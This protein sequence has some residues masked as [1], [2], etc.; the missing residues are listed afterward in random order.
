MP[1]LGFAEFEPGIDPREVVETGSRAKGLSNPTTLLEQLFFTTVRIETTLPDKSKSTGTGFIFNYHTKD[2]DF[3]YIVTN[4]H[5]VKNS[6]EGTLVFNRMQF[7]LPKLGDHFPLEYDNFEKHWTFHD[8]D[9]VDLA[10]LPFSPVLHQLKDLKENIYYKWLDQSF[11]PND[12]KI[13]EEFDAVEDLLFLGY[14]NNIY[15]KKNLTPVVRKGITATP[16][17]ENYENN[18]KFLVDASIFPGSSG[19]PIFIIK[20]SKSTVL[21]KKQNKKQLFLLGVIASVFIK[22]DINKVE[23]IEI[24]RRHEQFVKSAQMIDLG[25][26]FK[27]HLF[28]EM[29]KKFSDMIEGYLE[30]KT[31]SI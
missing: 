18:P 17:Y 27:S 22:T 21:D 8:D 25:I 6:I 1:Y 4:R 5:V 2:K 10:I 26:V 3:P 30:E 12:K 9:K 19:S 7:G 29:A 28:V 23:I 16:V 11:V 31:D 20:E 13:K 14:P 24:P 15:D